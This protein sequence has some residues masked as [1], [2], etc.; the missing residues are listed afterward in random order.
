MKGAEGKR[1]K[2]REGREGEREERRGSQLKFLATPLTKVK[3]GK[4]PLKYG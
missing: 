3:T 1:R 2:G 4:I